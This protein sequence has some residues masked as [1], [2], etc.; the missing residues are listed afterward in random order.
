M[1]SVN[2]IPDFIRQT[3]VST[4]ESDL[5]MQTLRVSFV[6]IHGH[7]YAIARTALPDAT[8]SFA[9]VGP[10]MEKEDPEWKHPCIL[11]REMLP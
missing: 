5:G 4:I 6:V 10:R 1:P 2:Q 11:P 3:S 8:A 7:F 9:F